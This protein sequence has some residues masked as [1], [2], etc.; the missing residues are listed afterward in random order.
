MSRARG[1]RSGKRP[2]RTPWPVVC[3][4]LECGPSWSSLRSAWQSGVWGQFQH[5]SSSGPAHPGPCTDAHWPSSVAVPR[6][7]FLSP[8]RF[9][10]CGSSPPD[11]STLPISLQFNLPQQRRGPSVVGGRGKRQNWVN[12]RVCGGQAIR[13]HFLVNHVYPSPDHRWTSGESFKETIFISKFKF[14]YICLTLA[15]SFVGAGGTHTH[16]SRLR[17]FNY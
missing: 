10:L 15:R 16:V 3:N 12:R 9:R 14:S 7:F 2:P 1:G 4:P 6:T 8:T 17:S 5:D 13:E 11:T